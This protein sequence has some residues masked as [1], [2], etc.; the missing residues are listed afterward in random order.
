MNKGLEDVFKLL[1]G[2]VIYMF[3]VLANFFGLMFSWAFIVDNGGGR[4]LYLVPLGLF[5][6]MMYFSYLYFN[7]YD[8]KRE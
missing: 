4:V 5:I 7:L 1:L 2:S 6:G 8:G 3:L